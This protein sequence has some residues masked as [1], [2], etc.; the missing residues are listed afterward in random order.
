MVSPSV[1][2]FPPFAGSGVASGLL[3]WANLRPAPPGATRRRGFLP[4]RLRR[5]PRAATKPRLHVL[6]CRCGLTV[7][8]GRLGRPLFVAHEG[9][10]DAARNQRKGE[11]P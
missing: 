7:R 5:L 1:D 9:R 6:R 8:S 4:R 10:G 3:H 11:K 2:V